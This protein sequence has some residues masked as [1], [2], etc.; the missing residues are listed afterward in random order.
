MMK[1][2][3]DNCPNGGPPGCPRSRGR[4]RSAAA[5]QKLLDAYLEDQAE[6][7]VQEAVTVL[8]CGPWLIAVRKM[9]GMSGS[10]LAT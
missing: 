4:R 10:A 3:T 7:A 1:Y 5:A 8:W 9:I 2:T 6:A